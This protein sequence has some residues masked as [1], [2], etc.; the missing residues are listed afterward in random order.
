MGLQIHVEVNGTK[1]MIPVEAVSS[2][3]KPNETE[4]LLRLN[5]GDQVLVGMGY[6]HFLE[7]Y[8]PGD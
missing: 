8:F 1:T 7:K 2:V 3:S 4:T 6:D 5:N